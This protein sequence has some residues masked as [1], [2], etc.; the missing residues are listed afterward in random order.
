[1]HLGR[2]FSQQSLLCD[3]DFVGR[4]GI[5]GSYLYSSMAAASSAASLP[6]KV[7]LLLFS[8]CSWLSLSSLKSANCTAF[9]PEEDDGGDGD[10]EG[11]VMEDGWREELKAPPFQCCLSSNWLPG[12]KYLPTLFLQM[13]DAARG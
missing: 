2:P 12:T 6:S 9:V 5:E 8:A 13:N 11:G 3:M 4:G 10:R 1:M 7:F